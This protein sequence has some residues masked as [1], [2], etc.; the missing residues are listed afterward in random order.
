M[1]K[2]SGKEQL[3][4]YLN[5]LLYSISQAAK[6]AGKSAKATEAEGRLNP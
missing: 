6:V 5:R 1:R 4:A 3:A 2:K